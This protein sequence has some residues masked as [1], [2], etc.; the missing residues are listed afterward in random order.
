MFRRIA[1]G[2]AAGAAGTAALNAVTYLDMAWRGRAAST[3]PEE[4]VEVLA[5]QTGIQIPGQG[6]QRAN[7]ITALGALSGIATGVGIGILAGVVGRAPGVLIGAAAMAATDTSMARLGVS[8]PKTWSAAD[9]A[10]DAVPHL[11]YGTVTAAV[12]RALLR[13]GD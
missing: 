4:S 1:A 11:A 5:K 3:T 10:A 9:W 13:D 8:D 7:R 6:E 2:A 12:L